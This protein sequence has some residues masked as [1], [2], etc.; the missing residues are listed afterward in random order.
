MFDDRIVHLT[1]NLPP[2]ESSDGLTL[3]VENNCDKSYAKACIKHFEAVWRIA[4]EVT[5][6]TITSPEN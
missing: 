6:E 3:E 1:I 5:I 2:S 4:Q